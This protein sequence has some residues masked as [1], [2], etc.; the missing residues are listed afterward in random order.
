MIREPNRILQVE[1]EVAPLGPP[2]ADCALSDEGLKHIEQ[3]SRA[4]ARNLQAERLPAPLVGGS[5][6]ISEDIIPF[7][8]RT[9]EELTPEERQQIRR[10]LD[11]QRV[12]FRSRPGF[13]LIAWAFRTK[14][15]AILFAIGNASLFCL[16]VGVMWLSSGGEETKES[17]KGT[18]IE[19]QGSSVRIKQIDE[20]TEALLKQ[21]EEQL[22]QIAQIE[23]RIEKL[24][25]SSEVPK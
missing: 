22:K 8:G 17:Y 10:W 14:T 5:V 18:M 11:A 16:V 15:R 6:S 13:D 7:S 12:G 24:E 25:K 20:R 3:T 23:T 1:D 9:S 21:I 4:F 19:V 2:G